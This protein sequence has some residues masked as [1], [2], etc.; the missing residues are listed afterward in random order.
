MKRIRRY[1]TCSG[2]QFISSVPEAEIKTARLDKRFSKTNEYPQDHDGSIVTSST[3]TADDDSEERGPK[4]NSS[5]W[6]EY[7]DGQVRR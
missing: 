3:H 7:S 1:L 5:V 6:A 4:A 2:S